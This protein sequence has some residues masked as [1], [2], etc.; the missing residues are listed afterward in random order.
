MTK[1]R[2]DGLI[3]VFLGAI[4]FLLIGTAW[5]HASA[6]ETG[7]FKVVYYSA[8]CLLHHGDPYNEGDVLRDYRAE[9]RERPNE[10]G[11]DRQ[12]KTR[13]FYP[14]TAFLFTLPF[15]VVGFAAGKMAWTILL[16]SSLVLAGIAAWDIA[17]DF[18]PL[19]AGLLAGLLLLNSFWL[20]MIGNSAGIAVSLCVLSAWCLSR[21][22]FVWMGVLLLAFSLALKPNDS[23]LVWLIFVLVG[24]S[25]RK[26][27]LQAFLLLVV[28]SLPML[29]WV[30]H[31]SPAWSLELRENMTS[32][33]GIGGIV[34][35]AATGMAGR[36]MD[37]LVQLQS[38]VSIFFDNPGTYNLIVYVLCAPLVAYLVFLTI[39]N[40]QDKSGIWLALAVAAPL[41][42]LPTYHFQHDA[43]IILL[44]IPA[45]SLL[46]A[47][48]GAL[49]WTSL[50]VTGTGIV[51][52][53]DVF[54]GTRILLTRSFMVPGTGFASR[55]TTVILTRPAPL[56]LLVM[57][58]FY[59]IALTRHSLFDEPSDLELNDRHGELQP[60]ERRGT[61]SSL[62]R[63]LTTTER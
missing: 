40:R 35:P 61:A 58:V 60:D 46:W 55:L 63:P 9:G 29:I 39:R 4:A 49:G 13:F 33:S 37:S 10:P 28:I 22:R 38:A 17:A 43:K 5:R 31:V 32:F 20:F 56:I 42:M 23:G 54:T 53:G 51:M 6:I 59:L 50:L 44:T 1:Q 19:V 15:A 21:N 26:R 3:L 16:A 45:C 2:K 47:K 41:S 27:A 14:P 8:R 24:G 57:A 48:R 52:C 7:D 18:A 34:D 12:V 62:F 11:L 30:S 36:N 25:F